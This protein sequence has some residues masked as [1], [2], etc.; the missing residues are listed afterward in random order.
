MIS[1]TTTTSTSYSA[2][3]LTGGLSYGFKVRAI[4]AYG[5]GAFSTV[6]T[7]VAG[8]A[9]S[10]PSTPTVTLTGI[11]AKI[12]W[13]APTTNNLAIDKYQILILSSDSSY[14]ENTTYCDG[15]S[16]TIMA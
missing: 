3:G 13:T 8:Q 1:L 4:N 12:T 11:Y 16:S 7:I 2:T 14:Y 6:S 5:N 15:S 9:P 10:T